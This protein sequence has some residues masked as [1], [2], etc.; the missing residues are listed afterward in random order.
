VQPPKN[1]NARRSV[2]L[3]PSVAA[4]LTE[5]IGAR[6]GFIFET[7]SGRPLG[8]SNLLNQELHPLLETLGISTKGF[9]AFRRYRNT[10]LRQQ[11]CPDSLL[12]TWMG[13]A[14]AAD[15]SALYDRSAQDLPYR[16][17]V[18]LAMGTGF[19]LPK[20]LTS[21]RPKPEELVANSRQEALTACND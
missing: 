7:C 3:H 10:F 4:V 14:S 17:D 11:R 18:A 2:D 1:Q 19:G 6:T 13:H 15:M 8:Q 20:E 5:F 21:K 12:K 16:K 9:H